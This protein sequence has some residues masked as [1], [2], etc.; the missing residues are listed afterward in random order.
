[1]FGGAKLVA[2]WA[3]TRSEW[4][5]IEKRRKRRMV[6][7]GEK[8]GQR[9]GRIGR[10]RDRGAIRVRRTA[11][12][13]TMLRVREKEGERRGRGPKWREDRGGRGG[14]KS[15]SGNVRCNPKSREPRPP[16]LFPSRLG[17]RRSILQGMA[18]QAHTL[19]LFLTPRR[20]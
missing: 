15:M 16:A 8:E 13:T 11:K 19:S 10:I 5:R 18:V 14:G 9:D 4:K 12:P 7:R 17:T 20:P 3:S 6:R 1:L 2:A